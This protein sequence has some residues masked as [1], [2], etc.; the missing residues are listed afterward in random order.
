MKKPVWLKKSIIQCKVTDLLFN[1]ILFFKR[2]K[3]LKKNDILITQM[4][5]IGD[6]VIRL[7]LLEILAEKY[8][9]EHM[10]ILT[11]NCCEILKMEGYNVIKCENS[12]HLNIIRLLKVYKQLKKYNFKELYMMEFKKDKEVDF[13][14]NFNYDMIYAY[15]SDRMEEW[16]KKFPVN[17]IPK[18]NGEIIESVY[19]YAEEIDKNVTKERL[20]PVLHVQ[21]KESDYIT[22]GVGAG[23]DYKVVSPIVLAEFLNY[24]VSI[25]PDTQFHIL[26]NGKNQ[27]KY[28]QKLKQLMKCENIISFVDKLSLVE[29]MEQIANAKLYIG[30]DSGL[31]NIAYA[32]NK[33]VL[34]IVSMKNSQSCYHT[35]KNIEFVYK[36]E[37][38]ETVREITDKTYTNEDL[39]QIPLERFVEKYNLLK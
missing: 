26:G 2:D 15:E 6:G 10:V 22:V 31:Y 37:N 23:G 1:C 34:A 30:F 13:L 12:F 33:K 32:L 14:I 5:G 29:S 36:Q 11:K 28:Y 38:D 4:D 3:K 21:T 18:S 39:N 9:K 24:I 17:L 27:E 8:G 19:N 7:G 35:S 20:K 25:Q 16:K